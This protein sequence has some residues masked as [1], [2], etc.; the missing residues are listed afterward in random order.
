MDIQTFLL[1]FLAAIV[2]LSIASVMYLGK[3]K[4]RN[5]RSYVLACLRFVTLFAL[6]ILIVN[7]KINNT[8]Y[9][10]EKA[11]LVLAVD[12][13][14]SIAY[15]QDDQKVKDLVLSI[16]NNPKIQEKFNVAQFRFGNQLM[17]NDSLS[18]S[19]NQT[20]IMSVFRDLQ[21]IYKGQ[22]APTLLVTDGNQTYGEAYQYAANKYKQQVIPIV[23][24]DTA[25][26]EDLSIKQLNANRYAFLKNK[27]P[28]EIIT[29]YNGST[30][31]TTQ[32]DILNGGRVVFSKPLSFSSEKSSEIVQ[33]SLPVNAIG[34]QTYTA[35]LK[36]MANER[37]TIN[38]SKSFGIQV[39][40]ERTK[41]LLLT[42]II[43]P[44][45]GALKKAI[46]SNEQR[47]VIIRKSS[48]RDII[49]GDYQMVILYQPNASFKNYY[50]DIKR[51]GLNTF[52]I[53]GTAT[54]VGFLND[55]QDMFTKEISGETEDYQATFNTNYNVFQVDDIGFTDFPPLKDTFG[56]VI[57]KKPG[58]SILD[59]TVARIPTGSTLLSTFEDSA[60]RHA[61]LF[62]AGVWRWRAQSF[63]DRQ[64]FQEFDE[65][66]AK[67]VQ[68]LATKERRNRLNM[69]YESFYN[70]GD[71][72][73]ISAQY[74]DKNYVFNPS[75]KLQIT[76]VS[77]QDNTR[78]DIPLLLKNNRYEVDLSSLKPDSY[79]FTV[80]AQDENIS[81][82]GSFEIIAFNVEQQ[83]LS[84]NLEPLKQ[85]ADAKGEEL[86]F[87]ND[88]SKIIN[89]L[90]QTES[91]NPIQQQ[92]RKIIPIIEWYY[93]L[94]IIVLAL[95]LEWFMRKYNGLI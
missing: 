62:G 82:S 30:A 48:E 4:D 95:A 5:R 65:F 32:L 8:S 60:Q 29:N 6:G 36:P 87:L 91:Y 12:N 55:I 81:R 1:L 39:I 58:Q 57:L 22:V 63:L 28:V 92:Q 41:I 51:L 21:K 90:L 16:T 13:S 42:S 40:D 26:Y 37:N 56:D 50:E 68:Y 14:E 59:Q 35:R 33:V 74:F 18:F 23:A 72:I 84:A 9:T 19:E 3:K 44:D 75:A 38:N 34:V 24:G 76:V 52:T 27:F 70:G 79:E 85:I 47:D 71:K 66:I 25:T 78:K 80:M 31:I 2:S 20:N 11:N 64:T 73:I 93:L 53:T 83:F 89:T 61:V 43:H 88:S 54:D 49:V 45:V 15:F 94:I 10:L 7:P 77:K 86:Y 17:R 69:T 67:L 46:E